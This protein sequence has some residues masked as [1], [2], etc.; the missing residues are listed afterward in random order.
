MTVGSSECWCRPN[1]EYR[2]PNLSQLR[3]QVNNVRMVV[4]STAVVRTG[5]HPGLRLGW[6]ITPTRKGNCLITNRIEHS[7][8]WRCVQSTAMPVT[9]GYNGQISI[10][11]RLLCQVFDILLFML[12]LNVFLFH[13]ENNKL[14]A[15]TLSGKWSISVI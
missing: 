8:A 9:L 14:E 12:L 2:N 10:Y 15:I 4:V 11:N 6:T 7:R 5:Q 1:S 3:E 13:S